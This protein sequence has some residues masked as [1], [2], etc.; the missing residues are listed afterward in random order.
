MVKKTVKKKTTGKDSV[1]TRAKVT[2]NKANRAKPSAKSSPA[3]KQSKTA[4]KS[5][6][7][8]KPATKKREKA[9]SKKRSPSNSGH[10]TAETVRPERVERRGKILPKQFLFDLAQTIKDAV[11]PAIIAGKG[12]EIVGSSPSGD[13]TFELDRIAEK[14]LLIFLK[15][16][17]KPVAYY[18]EES[19]YTTFSSGQP[20][21]L[22]VVDPIDGTRA[23]RSGFEYCVVTVS[24]TRVIE[25]PTVADLDNAC[26]MEILGDRSF[27]AEYGKGARVYSDGHLKKTRLSQNT[28]LES[29]SWSMTVPA[30][31]P[32]IGVEKAPIEMW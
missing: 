23:A 13:A 14:A 1:R 2:Q 29:V 18:S 25:R 19:G 20:T 22:L 3:K 7:G 31:P 27:Y 28:D 9:S 6:L 17:R 21:H 26:I 12:R 15:N 11:V 10:L 5:F 30:P 4:D 16:A 32:T 8:A 24:S